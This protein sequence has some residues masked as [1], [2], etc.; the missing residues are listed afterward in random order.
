MTRFYLTYYLVLIAF[1]IASFFPEYRVWGINWWAYYPDWGRW[2]LFGLGALI[3]VV[4]PFI[5]QHL[6]TL[7]EDTK[8]PKDSRHVFMI[9]AGSVISVF[10]VLFYLLRTKTHFLGDGY[11]LLHMLAEDRPTMTQWSEIGESLIH[12]AVKSII[13]GSGLDAALLANQIISIGAGLLFVSVVIWFSRKFFDQRWQHWLFVIGVLSGG[14]MQLFFGYVENY[15]LFTVSVAIHFLV[16]LK[17][18]AGKLSKFLLLLSLIASMS[19]HI[20]GVTLLPATT[21]LLLAD[22]FIGSWFSRMKTTIKLTLASSIVAILVAVFLYF[23]NTDY[24]FRFAFVPI[25]Q[26]RFTIEG[27]TMFSLSHLFDMVNLLVLLMPGIPILLVLLARRSVRS[28]FGSTDHRFILILIVSTIVAAFIFEAYLGM[29]RDWDLFSFAGIPLVFGMLFITLRSWDR[30]RTSIVP[31]VMSITLGF[32]LLMPRVI[33]QTIPEVSLAHFDNYI[34]LDKRKNRDVIEL[35]YNYYIDI[36]D[37]ISAKE[38]QDRWMREYPERKLIHQSTDLFISGQI[39]QALDLTRQVMLIDPTISSAY[40]NL[41]SYFI[42]TGQ[43]DSATANLRIAA[44]LTPNNAA[45]NFT[46]GV[47]YLKDHSWRR[48]EKAFLKAVH[49]DTNLVDAQMY[50][51][52]LYDSTGQAIKRLTTLEK[53]AHRK[54]APAT[55]LNK[56]AKYY[57]SQHDYQ[58]AA[59]LLKRALDNGLDS[60][61]VRQ[62]IQEYHALG[63]YIE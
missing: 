6:G 57:L 43:Y 31:V 61:D 34:K 62:L 42:L 26:D 47:A 2:G 41:G 13:G 15:S 56:L 33:S 55:A 21:Y 25:L 1:L 45:I 10:G 11:T 12:I 24:F 14:Y 35:L 54:E 8:T 37:Y 46:L 50:L 39:E 18:A 30:L 63:E 19:L 48:A 9:M 23:Y 3:P 60:S 7:T 49:L 38:T 53:V 22:S 58:Q 51:I 20:M 27:Y 32:L 36:G 29:P 4:V 40:H 28:L 17:V 44:G 5:M 16:G 52:D 59:K